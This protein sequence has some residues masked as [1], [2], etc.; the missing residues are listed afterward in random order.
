VAGRGKGTG[1]YWKAL[2][3]RWAQVTVAFHLIHLLSLAHFEL[4][5]ILHSKLS[6]TTQIK[7]IYQFDF[8]FL[9][10]GQYMVKNSHE[11]KVK[12]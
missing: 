12:K 11:S 5:L 10:R 9:I 8:I 3:G 6:T 1:R 7:K 4:S 2:G